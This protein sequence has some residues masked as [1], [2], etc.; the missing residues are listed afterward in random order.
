MIIPK[1]TLN[2]AYFCREQDMFLAECISNLDN[3]V[4]MWTYMIFGIYKSTKS[5]PSQIG[6]I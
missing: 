4:D 2:I 1:V 5:N 6:V 3:F